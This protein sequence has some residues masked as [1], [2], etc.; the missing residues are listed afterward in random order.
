MAMYKEAFE[1]FDTDKEGT[2]DAKELRFC[3]KVTV[4]GPHPP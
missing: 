1:L 4:R 3:M 2:I